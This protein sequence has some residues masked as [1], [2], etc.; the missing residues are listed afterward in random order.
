MKKIVIILFIV[1]SLIGCS[2]GNIEPTKEEVFTTIIKDFNNI[3]IEIDESYSLYYILGANDGLTFSILDDDIVSVDNHNIKG[4]KEGETSMVLK[5]DDKK[6]KVEVKV[7]SK[8]DL[9]STFSFSK[10]RLATKKIVAFGDSVTANTTIGGEKTYYNLFAD[11]YKMNAVK[12]YAIGG[13]TATYMFEGSNIY[14]EY[15]GNEIAID[16]VRVVKQ[17]Y[18]NNELSDIDYAFI[19][20]GHNDQYFQAPI[21]AKDDDKYD[22]NSFASCH[23]FKGS[24]RYMINTL[25]LANPNIRIIILGPTYSEYDKSNPSPYGKMYNYGDY[26]LATLEIANEF[27]LTYIDLWDH[28]KLY[29]DVYDAKLYYKDPVHLSSEGHKIIANYIIN[30]R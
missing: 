22:V 1:L 7:H 18:D 10:E 12:N 30:Y 5:L 6:Q 4:L 13:T 20:Y 15:N 3:D 25:R 28:M 29:F 26:R 2:N 8:D 11:E 9:Q 14:K 23:S 19:A 21:D 27:G 17:A 16:G 24:Y